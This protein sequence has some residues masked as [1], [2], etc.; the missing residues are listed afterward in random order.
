MIDNSGLNEKLAAVKKEIVEKYSN[1]PE[2]IELK[3]F[4]AVLP[5]DEAVEYIIKCMIQSSARSGHLLI[6]EP[7]Y[8]A[9]AAGVSLVLQQTGFKR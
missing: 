9:L 3:Q 5:D 7:G 4:V 1:D 2:F 6:S 8:F